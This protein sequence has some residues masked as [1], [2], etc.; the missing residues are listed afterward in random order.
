VV[1]L[2]AEPAPGARVVE[3]HGLDADAE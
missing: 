2:L 1:G 3:V